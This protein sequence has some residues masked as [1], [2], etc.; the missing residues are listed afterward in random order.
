MA[1]KTTAPEHIVSVVRRAKNL[2]ANLWKYRYAFFFA[3]VSLISLLLGGVAVQTS[4]SASSLARTPPVIIVP[5]S[6]PTPTP[7][8]TTPAGR[9]ILVQN[10]DG[11][12]TWV[13][14]EATPHII[15]LEPKKTSTPIVI[16]IEPTPCAPDAAYVADVTIL[17]HTFIASGGR[18]DKTWRVRNI[19]TCA[20]EAGT[21]LQFVS[22]SKLNGPDSLPVAPVAPNATADITVSM[23][24]PESPGTYTGVWQ[25]IDSKGNFFGQKLTIVIEVPSPTPP[26]STPTPLPPPKQFSAQLVRWWPN[27][28]ISL[29]KGKVVEPN[30]D[31]VNGL[32]VRVWA[33]G[34][35]GATSLVSG[36]GLTYGPGEWDVVLRQGQSGK[37]YVTVW[38]WQ[39]GPDS[40]TRVDSDVLVLDFNYT[41]EN[42]QPD[43]DGHQVAEV[44]FVRNY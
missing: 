43:G 31:P 17:D 6:T 18:F 33:D 21:Q 29:V 44:R 35:D 34:W 8:M 16:V 40:Y 15:I 12:E 24:A 26:T 36:I 14:Q 9:W 1:S 10:E 22:G 13:W 30:G 32:R 42:C 23:R 25:L 41:Q 39:T 5:I 20:W 37:F 19:G 28:G 11:F 27:C 4:T 2:L 7:T 3:A 38:D